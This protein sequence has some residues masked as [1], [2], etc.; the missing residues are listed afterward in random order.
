MKKLYTLILAL[1][2]ATITFAQV[3]GT[4]RMAPQ[5][6]AL[7]VG[8]TLGDISWW[9]NSAGDVI[10]RA[11]Y[12][13]DKFVFADDGTFSNVL[14]G[15]TW[16]EPWQ[17]TDPEACGVPVAPHD[18]SNA[19][20]WT[21][22]DGAGTVTLNGV[23]AYLGLPKVI[24]EAEISDP[25][26]A[27]ASIT[28]PVEFNATGDTMTIN[29]SIGGGYWRFI[30]TTQEGEPPPVD[31]ISLPVT[32]DEDLNYS[33]ADF[34]GS[35]SQIIVDPTNA[36]NKV[37]QTVK[38]EGAETWAGTTVSE[39]NG[40]DPAVPFEEGATIM[41]MKVFSP[42]AGLPV[43][44]KLEVWDNTTISVE[45]ITNT[46]V[47]NEWETLYFDFNNEVEETPPLD[48][49]NPYNK[50]VI[51]FNFDVSGADAGEMTFLWD[52]IEFV[53][54]SGINDNQSILTKVYPNPVTDMLY[55]ENS[56]NFEKISIYSV[57]GQLIYQSDEV[58]NTI[59]VEIFP[60]GMYT[61][62]ANGA[63]GKAYFAKFLV[64]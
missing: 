7:G 63:D 50:P 49:A 37:V 15:E 6:A 40:L 18:G 11:C 53:D 39:P 54:A 16:I 21:Y 62:R 10:T 28:Y 30:L 34:G 52:D 48:L 27:P 33:F 56:K 57:H 12:F 31:V 24:N 26:D 25:A 20:T 46:T 55:L 58:E 59:N 47:A 36:E 14:D 19:A 41:S 60:A 42:A 3:V 1:S 35:V 29:I 44:F 2:F 17:G 8:P 64:K 32:F 4:W 9:S 45:T 38:G 23:G 51:F 61:L 5:A 22:D 43:L 13:D